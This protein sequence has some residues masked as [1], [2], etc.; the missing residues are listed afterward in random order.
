CR[1]H[2]GAWRVLRPARDRAPPRSAG[3]EVSLLPDFSHSEITVE[4]YKD[5]RGEDARDVRRVKLKLHG[6]KS[7]LVD[8]GREIG[9]FINRTEQ[10][11]PGDF[12]NLSDGEL[13]TKL[14]E[15]FRA[16]GLT[17]EQAR[18]LLAKRP[19]D[20]LDAEPL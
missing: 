18:A 20:R 17:E 15:E 1:P 9:M 3:Y 14:F 7:A 10:G 11:Q 6:K 8:M 5:G 13:D 12:A 4:D 2:V 19:G 16:R